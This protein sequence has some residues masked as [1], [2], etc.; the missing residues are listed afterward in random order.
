MS[1]TNEDGIDVS[2]LFDGSAA[3]S[4]SF[5]VPPDGDDLLL[6]TCELAETAD[7]AEAR[8]TFGAAKEYD[9]TVLL[10]LQKSVYLV[11]EVRARRHTTAATTRRDDVVR[12]DLASSRLAPHSERHATVARSRASRD[13][14][15]ATLAEDAGAAYELRTRNGEEDVVLPEGTTSSDGPSSVRRRPPAP[16]FP[17]TRRRGSTGGGGYGGDLGAV[18]T[19]PGRDAEPF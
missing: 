10:A 17:E 12:K 18:P 6:M 2:A 5:A 13:G 11:A 4:V 15:V 14:S 9:V 8:V 16:R 1:C 19:T 7:I 3:T